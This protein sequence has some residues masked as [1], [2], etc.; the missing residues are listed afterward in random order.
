MSSSSE[1]TIR[2]PADLHSRPAGLL[3]RTAAGF[4]S[5]VMFATS[6]KE[7]EARSVLMVMAL[8][9]TAGTEVTV[10]AVGPDAEAAV[11]RLASMLEEIAPVEAVPA[12]R[13]A[14]LHEPAL[15]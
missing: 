15:D 13:P 3:S 2:L 6:S 7:A 5:K 4:Q 9:A 14:G 8:G 10:R 12:P 1:R 11:Q